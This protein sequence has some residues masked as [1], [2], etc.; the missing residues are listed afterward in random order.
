MYKL[1]QLNYTK[2]KQNK[3]KKNKQTHNFYNVSLTVARI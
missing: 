3:T 2:T 1:S